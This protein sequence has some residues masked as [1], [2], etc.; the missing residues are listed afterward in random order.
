MVWKNSLSDLS[1]TLLLL[2]SLTFIGPDSFV[3]SQESTT[4]Q[5][6]PSPAKPPPSLSFGVAHV[7]KRKPSI[8]RT[9]LRPY[10]VWQLQAEPRFDAPRSKRI[11]LEDTL[12]LGPEKKDKGLRTFSMAVC[13]KVE[14][15]RVTTYNE[16]ADELVKDFASGSQV[17]S[18]DFVRW[19]LFAR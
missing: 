7:R 6:T 13:K 3:L 17:D 4:S 19:G 10:I 12:G 16:V 11:R 5:E 2:R 18:D 14:Q 8:P 9:W 15:K 1:L